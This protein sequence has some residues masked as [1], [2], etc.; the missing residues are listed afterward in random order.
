MGG[1]A[2][3]YL[4]QLQAGLVGNID[5]T[6]NHVPTQESFSIGELLGI[7]AKTGKTPAVDATFHAVITTGLPNQ[8]IPSWRSLEEATRRSM[9]N[10]SPGMRAE[11]IQ[12]DKEASSIGVMPPG[13]R[14]DYSLITSFS[15]QRLRTFPSESLRIYVVGEITYFDVGRTRQFKTTFCLMDSKWFDGQSFEFCPIGNDMQ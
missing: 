6:T 12:R 8:S 4:R 10:I 13:Y 11:E 1:S 14:H 9:T 15:A 5:P 2:E 7:I 3:L